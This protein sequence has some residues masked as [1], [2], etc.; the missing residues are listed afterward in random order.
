MDKIKNLFTVTSSPHIKAADDTRSIMLTVL[1]ALIAPGIMSIVYYG[2]RPLIVILVSV[3]SCVAFEA[4]YCLLMKRKQT[5]GDFSAAVTGVL[6][7]YVLPPSVPYWIPVIGALFAIIVVKM[8]FGGIGCNIVNPAL[9]ARAFLMS[10]PVIMTTFPK[11][12]SKL[13]LGVL[14]AAD[15]VTSPTVLT[16]LE[17]GPKAAAL[18]SLLDMFI[19]EANGCIGETSSL[20]LLI[21]FFILV[22]RKVITWHIPVF[23]VGTVAVITFIFPMYGFSNLDFMLYNLLSGG[24]LLGAVFMATDYVTSPITRSGKI[25]YAVGCGLLTVFIRYFGSNPEGV[26]S[27]ILIMNILAIFID[28][29]TRPKRYGTGGGAVNVK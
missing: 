24:L 11:V 12:F 9:A 4:L 25:I 29:I 21:G 5:I 10:W 7:A 15:V 23:Y 2:L 28:K 3:A 13:S 8:L 1:F 26:C 17:S 22:V 20:F 18:P 27:A 16:V 6:L 14:N 19:G